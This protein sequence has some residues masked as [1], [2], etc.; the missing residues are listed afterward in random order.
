MEK[1]QV[2]V[3]CFVRSWV[4]QQLFTLRAGK[5]LQTDTQGKQV[6]RQIWSLLKSA[7]DT[8]QL[9][10]DTYFV[11][12]FFFFYLVVHSHDKY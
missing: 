3:S 11:S 10:R 8:E 12:V 5:D 1:D 2:L 7:E 9:F 6:E 4:Q